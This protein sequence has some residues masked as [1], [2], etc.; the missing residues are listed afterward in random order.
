MKVAL[1][2]H[3]AYS[4][5][6]TFLS[7][8]ACVWHVASRCMLHAT[9]FHHLVCCTLYGTP[10][11]IS[12]PA[13]GS[14]RFGTHEARAGNR[15]S[16]DGHS[17]RRAQRGCGGT[18]VRTDAAAFG[19]GRCEDD[20]SFQRLDYFEPVVELDEKGDKWY[21]RSHSGSDGKIL[22]SA[23]RR[24]HRIAIA[25]THVRSDTS[26]LKRPLD[27]LVHRGAQVCQPIRLQAP[28]SD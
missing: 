15:T 24:W 2:R 9:A 10:C 26:Q 13:Y 28:G 7:F 16:S 4:Q 25:A 19:T 3:V 17:E 6:R 5:P 11:I 12:Y 23:A 27:C 20:P 18:A 14:L 8:G 1:Q 22:K 21:L